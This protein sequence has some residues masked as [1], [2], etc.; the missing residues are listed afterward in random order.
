M[1][2]NAEDLHV[3]NLINSNEIVQQT[4]ISNYRPIIPRFILRHIV[5]NCNGKPESLNFIKF[6]L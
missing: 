1:E 2:I 4:Y 6:A 3:L 5:F